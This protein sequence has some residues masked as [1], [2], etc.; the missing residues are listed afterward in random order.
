MGTGD[1]S[2]ALGHS[3]SSTLVQQASGVPESS[4]HSEGT[5][6]QPAHGGTAPEQRTTRSQIPPRTIE[7]NLKQQAVKQCHFPHWFLLLL[8]KGGPREGLKLP[9]LTLPSL[10]CWQKGW[11]TNHG[12][13]L[14][15]PS[16]QASSPAGRSSALPAPRFGT[17]SYFLNPAPQGSISICWAQ[18]GHTGPNPV[19]VWVPRLSKAGP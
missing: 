11:F 18:A 7:R 5:Q 17:Q 16:S 12:S 8:A 19:R 10:P 14:A 6:E 13:C 4:T 2:T 9:K 1:S 15:L 3:W